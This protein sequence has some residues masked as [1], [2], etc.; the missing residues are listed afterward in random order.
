[1]V[2]GILLVWGLRIRMQDPCVDVAFWAPTSFVESFCR[3]N[4]FN[5]VVVDNGVLKMG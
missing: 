2:S 4:L 3:C 1:M 5:A